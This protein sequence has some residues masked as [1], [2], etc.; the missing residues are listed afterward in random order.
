MRE[1]LQQVDTF[2]QVLLSTFQTFF[3]R[4]FGAREPVGYYWRE[5]R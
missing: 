2:D 5:A 3:V 1:T 4:A